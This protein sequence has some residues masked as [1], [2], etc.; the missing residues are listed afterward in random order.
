MEEMLLFFI[1]ATAFIWIMLLAEFSYRKLN[2]NTLITRNIVQIL[3][4]IVALSAPAHNMSISVALALTVLFSLIFYFSKKIH[5]FPAIFNID[6]ES[7]GELFFAWSSFLLFLLYKYTGNVLYFYLP[8]STVV[9][10][11]STAALIGKYF[12]GKNFKYINKDKTYG[13]SLAFFIVTFL[14][15][16]YYF[17]VMNISH[18]FLL[19]LI[20]ALILTLIE[21]VSVRGWDNFFISAFSAVFLYFIQ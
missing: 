16:F 9:F 3:S 5:M 17:S 6:R 10:A 14:L 15:S 21:A 4:G 12:P 20:N 13:G 7:Y 18:L 1:Y 11:D 8:L 19:S 2:F